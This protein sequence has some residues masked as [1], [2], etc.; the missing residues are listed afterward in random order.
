MEQTEQFLADILIVDD[1]PANIQLLSQVLIEH[2]YKVRKLISGERALKAVELQV[3][4]LILLDIKMPGMDGYE[5]C[6]QLKASEATCAIPVIFISALDDVFDKVKGFEAGGAD[7]IIKPFEPVEVL[8]RVSAQLKM[9]RLQQQLRCANVQLAA[10]NV[11][12]SQ[13]IQERQ[14]AEANL[15]MLLHA[16]SHDLRSPLS[17][18]SLLLRSRLN[19]AASNIAIDRRTVEVMVQSCSRQLQ[20]IE[21]LTATQQFDIKSDSLAIK[22]LSLATLVQNILI[23]RLPILNQHRVKV[24]QLFAADLPLVNADAQQLWRVFGNLIDNAVKYNQS[25]F[26]LTVEANKEGKM[27]RCT[28]ADNGA[29]ISPQQCARLFEPYTRGVGVSLRQG[30]GLGLYICRQIVEAHGGEIGVDSEL[31]KGAMFWLT[32]P[33]CEE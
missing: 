3:P 8:A 1:I 20:L 12:L 19:D 18:M 30:L 13:E 33:K 21:S 15:K 4:D 24:K 23:E 10:Q 6:R 5:V 31:G 28:V 25:G 32:L 27:V 11:Q 22:P 9:Q 7:Y 14:Q 2:G 16:V 29:G 17:G 26:I